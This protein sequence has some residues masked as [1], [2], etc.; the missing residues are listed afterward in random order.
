MAKTVCIIGGGVSGLVSV[1]HCIAAGLIPTCYESSSHI[2]GLWNSKNEN[3]VPDCT[4]TNTSKE[5]SAFSDFP[6]PASF[7]NFMHSEK[8]ME[9]FDAYVAKNDLMKSIQLGCE[10]V[11]LETCATHSNCLCAECVK[12]AG[13]YWKVTV[14]KCNKEFE[15]Y[16]D[17]LIVATG[18]N[19]QPFITEEVKGI[20]K[21]FTGNVLHSSKYRTWKEFENQNVLVYGLGNSGGVIFTLTVFNIDS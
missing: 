5:L 15:A 1:K 16:Y 2:G 21:G 14:L 17:F 4:V 13:K 11:N 12:S 19:S 7:P 3:A 20:L 18:F 6:M 10:V 8:L 9:Y